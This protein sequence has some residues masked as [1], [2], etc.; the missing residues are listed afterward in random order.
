MLK[1]IDNGIIAVLQALYGVCLDLTGLRIGSFCL[2]VSLAPVGLGIA[3]SLAMAL[4]GNRLAWVAIAL[5]VFI[6]LPAMIFPA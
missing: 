6:C 1:R 2:A 3:V 5:Y 4:G